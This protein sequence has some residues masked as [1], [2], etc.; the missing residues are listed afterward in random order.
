MSS[1]AFARERLRCKSFRKR[2]CCGS[3]V[4]GRRKLT[5]VLESEEEREGTRVKGS[6]GF[7]W[8]EEGKKAVWG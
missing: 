6:V 2:S 1:C 3:R 4:R 5:T 7:V 8:M